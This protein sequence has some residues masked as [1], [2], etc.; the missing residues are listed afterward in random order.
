MLLISQP[1]VTSVGV[2]E[3][4][5]RR[6]AKMAAGVTREDV[7]A[8]LDALCD[9]GYLLVDD[10][11]EEVLVRSF[12][13]HNEP[14]KRPNNLVSARAMFRAVESSGRALR[15][16]ALM[17][18]LHRSTHSLQMNTLGPAISFST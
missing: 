14:W 3:L 2:L 10:E 17:M 18:S 12:V 11:T 4:A 8:A 15:S 9:A 6:W 13:K 16:S 7:E 1:L 5:P